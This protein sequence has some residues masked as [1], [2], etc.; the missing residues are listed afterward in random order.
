MHLFYH[1][2]RSVILTFLRILATCRFLTLGGFADFILPSVLGG[3]AHGAIMG[4]ANVYPV[5][6]LPCCQSKPLRLT[7]YLVAS[8]STDLQSSSSRLLNWLPARILNV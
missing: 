1:G 5:S 3:K 7:Q 4:L 8:Y 6:A 2:A